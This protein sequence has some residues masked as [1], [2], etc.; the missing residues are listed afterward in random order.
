MIGHFWSRAASSVE[1][2][3]EDEVT[4]YPLLADLNRGRLSRTR[5]VKTHHR[6]EGELLLLSV[7]EEAEDVITGDDTGLAGELVEGTHNGM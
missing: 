2:T 3:T 6:G 5:C 4:F 1:T 7:L